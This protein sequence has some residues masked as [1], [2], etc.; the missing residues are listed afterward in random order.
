MA[1]L[2]AG[3]VVTL[4][5]T[6][7]RGDLPTGALTTLLVTL[8]LASSIGWIGGALLGALGVTLTNYIRR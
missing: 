3:L 8:L 1:Y 5:Y 7:L 2:L 4:Y 6:T